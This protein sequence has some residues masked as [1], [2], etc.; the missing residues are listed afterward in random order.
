MLS[1]A[2]AMGLAIYSLFSNIPYATYASAW[3]II[4]F[5]YISFVIV[6][7]ICR[8]SNS[9]TKQTR[10]ISI[11]IILFISACELILVAL[12]VRFKCQ[13]RHCISHLVIVANDVFQITIATWDLLKSI[14][15]IYSL[16]SRRE[17][18]PNLIGFSVENDNPKKPVP[19]IIEPIFMRVNQSSNRE[20]EN[21]DDI[22]ISDYVI[23]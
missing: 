14:C 23:C 4:M 18:P 16:S 19:P 17:I 6:V 7:Y 20:I 8:N 5:V 10:M 9:Q 1:L 2:L 13:T 15:I 3:V 12:S 22:I 11:K 21:D